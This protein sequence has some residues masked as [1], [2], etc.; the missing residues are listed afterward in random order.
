M[1]LKHETKENRSVISVAL[2]ITVGLGSECKFNFFRFRAL[3][4]NPL[5]FACLFR[6][7][8]QEVK[9]EGRG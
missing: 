1:S 3:T 8:R 2:R 6:G 9:V 5:R 7:W 4:S